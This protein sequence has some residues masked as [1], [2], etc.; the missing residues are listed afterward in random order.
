MLVLMHQQ[1]RKAKRRMRRLEKNW[2]MQ[3]EWTWV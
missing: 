3:P 2:Q 1:M